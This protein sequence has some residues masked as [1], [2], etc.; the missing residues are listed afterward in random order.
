VQATTTRPK[1]TPTADGAGVVSHVGAR[2]LGDP[3]DW[4]GLT[5]E[6]S[7]G[8]GGLFGRRVRH[9]PGRVLTDLAVAV[10]D[11]AEAISDIAT[12][13]DQ[14]GLFGA[15]ASD[16]TVWRLLDAV[17]P[18]ELAAICTARLAARERVWAQRAASIGNPVPP[19]R[20]GRALPGL[21]IDLDATIVVCHSDKES[22]AGTYKGSFGY[23]PMLAYLDNTGEALAGLLRAGN[24]GPS[25]A[26]DH[27]TVL[28][29]AWRRSLPNIGSA[30]RSWC[31]PTRRVVPGSSRPTYAGAA[32][33]V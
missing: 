12:L 23:A 1:I 33:T 32:N 17:G 24:A 5:A 19:A 4:S 26:A 7:V 2:L 22:A 13:A 25:N 10:A 28:D 6:L 9:D 31:A 20:A 27:I 16:S 29:A 15:V 18:D 11:G 3:A 30:S 14:P 21:V 8:L